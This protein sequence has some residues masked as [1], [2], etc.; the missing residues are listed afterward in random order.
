MHSHSLR[1]HLCRRSAAT[2][3]GMGRIGVITC[4]ASP[5]RATDRILRMGYYPNSAVSCPVWTK[6]LRRWRVRLACE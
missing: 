3:S 4:A 2:A 5:T 6:V 1:L